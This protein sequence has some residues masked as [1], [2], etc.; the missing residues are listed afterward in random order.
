MSCK[1]IVYLYFICLIVSYAIAEDE[2]EDCAI[3]FSDTMEDCDGFNNEYMEIPSMALKYDAT[4]GTISMTG[5][6]K[7]LKTIDDE[8]QLEIR[9]S[10]VAGSSCSDVMWLGANNIC[11]A[12][13]EQDAPWYPVAQQLNVKECPIAAEEF[14]LDNLLMDGSSASDFCAPEMF[15]DYC[16]Q[17]SVLNARNDPVICFVAYVAIEDPDDK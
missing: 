3:V 2:E 12:L 15:G 6:L 17:L 13:K 7:L 14:L 9:L 1:F 8:Y 10:K 4:N 11:G 5:I 16:I